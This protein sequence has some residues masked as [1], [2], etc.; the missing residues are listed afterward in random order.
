MPDYTK[1]K[2]WEA[3]FYIP[4]IAKQGVSYGKFGPYTPTAKK[5]YTKKLRGLMN[6]AGCPKDLS[7]KFMLEGV[8]AFPFRKKESKEDLERGWAFHTVRPDRDNLEKPVQDALDKYVIK[9]D[10]QLCIGLFYKIRTE[11]PFILLKLYRI[12]EKCN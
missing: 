1:E 8:F 5:K 4:P 2:V 6:K 12:S 10:S 9:D 3:T 11:T 7:G